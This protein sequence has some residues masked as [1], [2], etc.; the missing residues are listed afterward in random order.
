MRVYVVTCNARPC[1][2]FAN[3]HDARHYVYTMQPLNSHLLW[4]VVE[5]ILRENHHEPHHIPT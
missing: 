5:F 4:E 1:A 3:E 2:V